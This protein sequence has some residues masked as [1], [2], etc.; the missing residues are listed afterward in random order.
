MILSILPA[1]TTVR[2]PMVSDWEGD[3]EN[4][5]RFKSTP[6]WEQLVIEG[7]IKV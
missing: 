1:W 5:S 6:T 3:L 4:M 7:A 2:D